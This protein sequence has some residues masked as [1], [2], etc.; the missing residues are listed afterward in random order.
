MTEEPKYCIRC[1]SSNIEEGKFYT[2]MGF[3]FIPN[4]KKF[5]SLVNPRVSIRV[6]MCLN[7][8]HIELIG[9]I[10]KAR[11]IVPNITS[12]FAEPIEPSEDEKQNS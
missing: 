12:G 4:N 6:F 8:G 11:K 10:E 1:K 3:S 2:N 7:C 5:L 9:D